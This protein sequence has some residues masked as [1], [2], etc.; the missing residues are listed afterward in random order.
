MACMLH[1]SPIPATSHKQ[2]DLCRPLAG[3]GVGGGGD[4]PH[5]NNP[6][7]S[8]AELDSSIPLQRVE[9]SKA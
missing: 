1:E 9:T 5:K 8:H 7:A 4:R 3:G 2:F 6:G